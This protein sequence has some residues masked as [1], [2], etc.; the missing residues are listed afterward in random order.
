MSSSAA[1]D[2]LVWAAAIC[3][4][5]DEILDND[6]EGKLNDLA[7][8][9]G[10]CLQECGLQ[11]A[12]PIRYPTI[13]SCLFVKLRPDMDGEVVCRQLNAHGIEA[14]HYYVPIALTNSEAPVAW[15]LFDS[16]VCLPFH[17]E[18]SKTD[19]IAMLKLI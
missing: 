18:I 14:K 17:L 15:S 2:A 10:K 19:L 8:F 6:W 4:H 11:L 16:T 1:P 3:D 5:F 9:A 13:L 12:I 7:Q